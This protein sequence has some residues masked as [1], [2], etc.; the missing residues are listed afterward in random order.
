MSLALA[1]CRHVNIIKSPDTL[2][3]AAVFM[4]FSNLLQH[5]EQFGGSY[6]LTEGINTAVS[7]RVVI[8]TM[9]IKQTTCFMYEKSE[10]S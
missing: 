9:G 8:Q 7:N 10:P 1:T 6:E 4:C 3:Y 2:V 5:T